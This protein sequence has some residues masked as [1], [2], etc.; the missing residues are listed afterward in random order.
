[1]LAKDPQFSEM[2][3]RGDSVAQLYQYGPVQAIAGN[4]DTLRKI[5]SIAEPNLK[6]LNTFLKEGKSEKFADEPILGR[7]YA[8]IRGTVAAVRRAKPNIT[9]REMAAVRA[10]LTSSFSKTHLVVGTD[11]QMVMKAFPNPK[12]APNA[13]LDF[14]SGNG[15]W[16]GAN[17]NYRFEFNIGGADLKPTA[18]VEGDRMTMTLDK[19]A[20]VFDREY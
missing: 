9:P 18:V 13:A 8:N 12:T 20:V 16:S 14:Q 17:G 2:R 1:M 11:G 5:W 4:P 3:V 19:T 7:W 10:A 15:S 6:D